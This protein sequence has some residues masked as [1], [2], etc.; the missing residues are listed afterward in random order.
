MT[1]HSFLAKYQ[2]ALVRMFCIVV[3]PL[4]SSVARAES[5]PALIDDFS[6]A[7]QTHL[8]TQRLIIDDK[9]MGSQ[10][11]ATQTCANGVL[12]VQGELV[13]GR[14]LPAFISVPLLLA[15]DAQPKDLSGY[16]GV[17]IRVKITKGI[18]TVQV[19]SSEIQNFDFHT[20][21]AV[22]AKRGEF[23]EVRLPFKAMKR[24]WSEQTPLN[25]KTVTSVNLVA[26]GMAKDDFA[27]EVDEIGFY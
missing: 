4:V 15:N 5:F 21:G 19:A 27:Y 20:S 10:S 13:P 25:L 9:A 12:S 1:S 2:R 22:A 16:E 18:L 6:R 7:D 17:R 14:G 3:L 26:F 11:H 24:G 8:G 23:Q